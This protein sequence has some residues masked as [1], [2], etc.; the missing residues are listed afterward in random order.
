MRT[1]HTT[2]S[3]RAL[4]G[5]SAGSLSYCGPRTAC[6]ASQLCFDSR[7]VDSQQLLGLCGAGGAGLAPC[8]Q[9]L[10][11]D[12]CASL[13]NAL[14]A[15]RCIARASSRCTGR[16]SMH[17]ACIPSMRRRPQAVD[18]QDVGLGPVTAGGGPAAGASCGDRTG[19]GQPW[20]RS[21]GAAVLSRREEVLCED[22]VCLAQDDDHRHSQA[23]AGQLARGS[24]RHCCVGCRVSN[25]P[26]CFQ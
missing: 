5:P 17:R 25:L 13:F 22:E 14:A 8:W 20:R 1:A 3:S 18:Y 21:S 2:D 9:A 26:R 4:V 19:G 16:L 6:Q 24:A 10:P 7:T 12:A 23:G 15:S 11:L